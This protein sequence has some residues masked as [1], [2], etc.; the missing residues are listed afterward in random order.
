MPE[1]P[2]VVQHTQ[3]GQ[4]LRSTANPV[5]Y[6]KHIQKAE[7]AARRRNYDFAIQ[8]YQQL[9]E[10]N[11]DVGDARAGLRRVFKARHEAK[12]G[13]GL[14][15]KL[16]GAAPLAAAK[17]MARAGRWDAA[18][19]GYE[20]YLATNPLD[21]EGNLLLGQALEAGGYYA[22]ALAVFEFLAEI[23]PRNS[24]GL[25][26]AGA[27]MA[28]QGDPAKALAYYERALE[29]DPRDRDAMKARKDLAAEAA[30]E[31]G[32]FDS[33]DHSR[34][35]IVDREETQSL[36]RA[37]RLQMSS[38]ELD[39]EVERLEARLAEDSSD[40]EVM[41]E[42]AR[43]Q[44]KRRDPGAA[45]DLV[46]RAL[47]FRQGDSELADR[48]VALRVASIKRQISQADK[49]GDNEAADRLEAELG[50]LEGNRLRQM[51]Q[52]RPG[53]AS[54]RLALGRYLLAADD[55]DGAAAELQKALADPRLAAEGHFLLGLCFRRL[56]FLDLARK[57]FNEAL[58]DQSTLDD[59]GREILYNLGG[60]AE[61]E[62]ENTEARA[63]YS[64]IFET[65][66]GYRDV[67]AKMEQLS[68]D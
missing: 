67:A 28:K 25:K 39:A 32:R 56:S 48:A 42:L 44:E 58:E 13:R 31:G 41:L 30:L 46:E 54:S 27:M 9:L 20:G 5:D 66:I 45:L 65:D 6:S 18:I 55:L 40:V 19:K 15:G 60:I 53:D 22:S 52:R 17:G 37:N 33:V 10:I 12:G 23:A 2:C 61:A 29:A 50:D 57:Q 63:F 47:T 59:R 38:E 7:E 24:E 34:E 62:G 36:E 14:L 11:P 16:K 49:L 1:S 4:A 68:K 35:Q 26:S 43:V 64:R 8:L 51:V 3:T 21:E